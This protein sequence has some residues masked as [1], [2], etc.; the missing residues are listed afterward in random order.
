VLQE[1]LQ[2][3]VPASGREAAA[4]N[5]AWAMA[6][7]IVRRSGASPNVARQLS[8]LCEK[9][10]LIVTSQSGFMSV[11][12]AKAGTNRRRALSRFVAWHARHSR[13]LGRR[14][15]NYDQR[16]ADAATNGD[17]RSRSLPNRADLSGNH[18]H[19]SGIESCHAKRAALGERHSVSG[20][21][22]K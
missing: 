12:P 21:L 17:R 20:A 22:D 3:D 6:F 13:S 8:G 14:L 5:E 4:I 10:G 15:R 16:S 9:T 11:T 19:L 18:C 2:A 7:D 1:P